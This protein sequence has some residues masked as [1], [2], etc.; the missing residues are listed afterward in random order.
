M[1][2]NDMA[3]LADIKSYLNIA[4]DLSDGLLAL[5]ITAMSTLVQNFCD[6]PFLQASYDW[7][8]NGWGSQAMPIPYG[9]VQ[10]ITSVT[11]DGHQVPQRPRPGACGWIYDPDG[12]QVLL[13]GFQFCPG[14]GNVEIYYTAG[15]A[16]QAALPMDLQ[17]AIWKL[18]GLK[19][20]EPGHLDKTSETN[21]GATTVAYLRAWAP[22]DVV[23]LL[24]RYQRRAAG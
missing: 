14:V 17:F 5:L 22:E 4:D 7:I 2:T 9:P 18:V 21:R 3:A 15:Y 6:D 24:A 11:V 23:Q 12:Q 13:S 10:T 16:D 19:F 1:A 20:K 8:T